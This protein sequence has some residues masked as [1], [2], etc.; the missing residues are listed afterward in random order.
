MKRR[1]FIALAAGV[2][3]FAFSSTPALGE[4]SPENASCMG[5][6]S[7]FYGQFAPEQRAFVS[8]AVNDAAGAAGLPPGSVYS[9]FAQEKEGGA[10]PAPCGTRLE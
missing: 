1:S 6:G 2:A 8:D 10:I 7:A 9:T 4:P 3:V 5:L